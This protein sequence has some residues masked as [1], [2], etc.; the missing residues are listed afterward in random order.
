VAR[1][2]ADGGLPPYE[3][4]NLLGRR[5]ARPLGFED[6]I[7]LAD[8]EPVSSPVTAAAPDRP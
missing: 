3:L 6:A 4:E 1:S 5:L 7:V 2:P 8:L